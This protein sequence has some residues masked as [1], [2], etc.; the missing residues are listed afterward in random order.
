M[1]TLK[2]ILWAVALACALPILSGCSA[3]ELEKPEIKT[4]DAPVVTA[5]LND[6]KVELE[7]TPVINAT[8]YKVEYKNA[9]ETEFAPA[10]TVSYSP[11]VFENLELSNTY[12][13]RVKAL[14]GET[15][16]AWSEIVTVEVVRLLPVPAVTFNPGI[17]YIDVKW[18]AIEGVETYRVEY[19][20][21]AS[22]EYVEAYKG[23]GID[24]E[25]AV[26]L[27][28]LDPDTS[29][30]IR[31]S[32]LA[33]GYNETFTEVFTIKTTAA[34]SRF[35]KTADEFIAWLASV[36]GM[37]EETAALGADIDMEGK[38]FTSATGFAGALEGQGYSIRNLKT[39]KPLFENF[40]GIIS[41][42]VI[43]ESCE[44]TVPVGNKIFGIIAKKSQGGTFN[45]VINKADVTC[46]AT[47]NL[48]SYI[49]MGGLVGTA[50]NATFTNCEN[51]GK[52]KFDATGYHHRSTGI[53]GLV[54]YTES[55]TYDS[56][57]NSGAV[58][59]LADYGD[60]NTRFDESVISSNP[61]V[62]VNLGGVVGCGMDFSTASYC[63]NEATGVIT[64][65]HTKYDSLAQQKG[66]YR[67]VSIGGI[68]GRARGNMTQCKN[69]AAINVS[70]TGSVQNDYWRRDQYLFNIGG[71]AG[72]GR[73]ALSFESC[74]NKGNI[75]FANHNSTFQSRDVSAVGGIC[76][77]QD[78]DASE[79]LEGCADIFAYYCI[80]E[81]N[82]AKKD[83]VKMVKI[84]LFK[85]NNPIP[86]KYRNI[87][88]RYTSYVETLDDLY[89]SL[90]ENGIEIVN[91]ESEVGGSIESSVDFGTIEDVDKYGVIR[92]T[93]LPIPDIIRNAVHHYAGEPYYNIVIND[94]DAYGL[95]LLEYR[96]DTP[97]YLYRKP[98]SKIFDNVMLENNTTYFYCGKPDGIK[99]TLE[100]F[101]KDIRGEFKTENISLNGIAR[102]YLD[103]LVDSIIGTSNPGLVYDE[104]GNSYIFA[105]V[106]YG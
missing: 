89:N 86:K 69:Y 34:P 67:Q 55:S 91:D 35:I 25:Y 3:G 56:C 10:G 39:D 70:A 5:V 40:S 31:M 44:F 82:M 87:H 101:S 42:I 27:N 1:K 102:D 74:V 99:I 63:T 20:A 61:N 71:V 24:V 45:S 50:Y 75:S 8:S 68:V 77:W 88:Y 46:T 2:N 78:Y 64:F 11:Y 97:M 58:T 49:I 92:I 83:D 104:N 47:A 7:W 62:G 81:G 12:D 26:K 41:D 73:Y 13:F 51:S 79:I 4:L 14:C 30:D 60:P 59:L 54:G 100:D 48:D 19:K 65:K 38:E 9:T 53:G 33:E 93:K 21:P 72:A 15:E 57:V 28:D 90:I 18:K 96:Y 23:D 76:G 52:I 43:D 85:D 95:E 103:K 80:M 36:D 6:V 16:S 37:N 106:E 22:A 29:Y 94:L 98:N 105:R 84:K 66:T 32:C 17:T